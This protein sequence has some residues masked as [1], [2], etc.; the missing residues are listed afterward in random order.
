MDARNR[1][2][3][4]LLQNAPLLLFLVLLAVFGL[5]SDRF[6]TP[7]NFVNILIQSAFRKEPELGDVPLVKGLAGLLLGGM[8]SV[9]GAVIGVGIAYLL[10]SRTT[11]S[12]YQAQ[13]LNRETA[14]AE[15]AGL[16]AGD[17]AKKGDAET[18]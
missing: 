10:I 2:R 1:L 12:M 6:L 7:T 9:P 17:S 15:R 3:L 16:L 11:V 18:A 13:R 4:L 8:G 14:A 5:L